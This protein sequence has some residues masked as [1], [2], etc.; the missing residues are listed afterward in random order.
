MPH[1]VERTRH[2]H[3]ELGE[4]LGLADVAIVT[5]FVGTPGRAARGRDRPASCSTR[6]PDPTRRVWAPTLDDASRL[7]LAL[8]RPGDVVVTLGVGEPWRV[9]R[10]IVEGLADLVEKA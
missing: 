6:V 10:A 4:A 1:V 8:L 9:A 2:L 5:D 7:A 3:R